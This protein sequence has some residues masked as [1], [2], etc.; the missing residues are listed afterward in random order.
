[1]LQQRLRAA[2]PGRVSAVVDFCQRLIQTPSMPGAEGNIAAL[3]QREM[4]LLGYD[5][6]EVDAAGNVIG[7]VRGGSGKTLMLNTHLDHVDVGNPDRWPLPPFSGAIHKD[8]IWGRGAMDIKGPLACQ[9]HA[10]ALLKAA[11][12]EPAGDLYVT[13]TVMEEVGGIGAQLLAEQLRPDMAVVG[14]ASRCQ[15]ARGH[16]GRVEIEV[17]FTGRGAHASIPDQAANPHY[18]VARFLQAVEAM[19]MVENETFGPATVAPTL[20]TSDQI[21]RNVIPEQVTVV[22]DW[23]TVPEEGPERVLERVDALA[24]ETLALLNE[25]SLNVSMKSKKRVG[26]EAAFSVT[27]RIPTTN[28]KTYTGLEFVN[29]AIFPAFELGAEH[30]LIQGARGALESVYDESVPIRTWRFATDGGHFMSAGIPTVGFG[31]GDDRL[32]H[33]TDEHISLDQMERGLL[34]NAALIA[35]LGRLGS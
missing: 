26:N 15:V 11:G 30:A 7:F 22:L 33:T 34:G 35:Q 6:V 18:A 24:R 3:V 28:W 1:M 5:G 10:P 9:V 25:T 29:P 4:T 27:S 13:C 23:R 8:A 20:Y 12:I 2:C 31:P 17:C 19:P 21:S 16:R 32:A 14:E